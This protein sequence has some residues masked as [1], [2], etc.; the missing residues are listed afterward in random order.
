VL[1]TNQRVDKLL[2]R[3]CL[4]IPDSSH[5]G[6]SMSGQEGQSVLF[7]RRASEKS[8]AQTPHSR[9]SKQFQKERSA[10]FA[11]KLSEKSRQSQREGLQGGKTG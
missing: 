2:Q 7:C 10:N 3:N 4:E 8:T 9:F 6:T 1:I 5:T 11:V